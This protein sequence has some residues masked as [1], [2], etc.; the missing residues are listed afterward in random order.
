MEGNTMC[1][2]GNITTGTNVV[3]IAPGH[4]YLKDT[5]RENHGFQLGNVGPSHGHYYKEVDVMKSEAPTVI[6]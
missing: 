2:V 3:T 4:A 5:V 1:T 6:K